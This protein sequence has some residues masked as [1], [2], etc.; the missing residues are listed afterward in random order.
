[1]TRASDPATPPA[2][3]AAVRPPAVWFELRLDEPAG[4]GLQRIALEQVDLIAWHAARSG[5]ADEHVHGVRKTSKRVRAVLRMIRDELGE[6]VYRRDN[7][8]VRDVARELSTLRSAA[9]ELHILDSLGVWLPDLASAAVELRS[10]LTAQTDR[11]RAAMFTESWLIDDL[12]SRLERAR[13]SIE[14]WELPPEMIPTAHGLHHTYRHGRRGMLRAYGGAGAEAFH[15][16]RKRVK[17]LRHQM[18]ILAPTRAADEP[19][20]AA[21]FAEL[22]E[23]LGLEH[24]LADLAHTVAATPGG[25]ASPVAQNELLDAITERRQVLQRDLRPLAEGLYAQKPGEFTR[26]MTTAWER[27][28]G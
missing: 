2:A 1:M 11:I 5:V 3:G 16:W 13:A 25:F 9:V 4:V 22:G 7:A 21:E 18:E 23:G 20:I 8:I 6:E 24:D 19:S 17:Y 14:T 10:R 15:D 26:D 12:I 27:W 28:R